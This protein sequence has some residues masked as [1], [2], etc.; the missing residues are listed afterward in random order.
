MALSQQ[1]LAELREEAAA[2]ELR[3]KKRAEEE[4][5]DIARSAALELL[6]KAETSESDKRQTTFALPMNV[7][8]VIVGAV[9]EESFR[10]RVRDILRLTPGRKMSIGEIVEA[11][12]GSGYRHEGK[13]P[14]K[15]KVGNE[16]YKMSHQQKE[17]IGGNGKGLYWSKQPH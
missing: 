6:L 16:L 3:R 5:A 12:E 10:D 1:T 14:I 15:I 4:K 2:I 13:T 11:L 8:R 7:D 17:L 9:G